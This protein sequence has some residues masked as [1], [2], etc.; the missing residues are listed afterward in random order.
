MRL[1]VEIVSLEIAD[2]FPSVNYNENVPLF[3]DTFELVQEEPHSQIFC[4]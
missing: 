1:R 2:K 3:F 4:G